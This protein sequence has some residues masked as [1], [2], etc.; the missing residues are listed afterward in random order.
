MPATP[1]ATTQSPSTTTT[2]TASTSS[3]R[4]NLVLEPLAGDI[5]AVVDDL[6]ETDI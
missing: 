3:A 5:Y 4:P 2:N 6:A 1:K